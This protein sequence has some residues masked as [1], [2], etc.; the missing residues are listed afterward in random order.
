MQ[1]NLQISSYFCFFNENRLRYYRQ[2]KD[3]SWASSSGGGR[4][5]SPKMAE[6]IRQFTGSGKSKVQDKL[7]SDI[8]I[9]RPQ[10]VSQRLGFSLYI[11]LVHFYCVGSILR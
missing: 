2:G 7:A 10:I 6:T 11:F 8:A 5:C 3:I 1:R 9:L 4:K